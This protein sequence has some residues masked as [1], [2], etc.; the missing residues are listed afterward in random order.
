MGFLIPVSISFYTKGYMGSK[1]SEILQVW[2]LLES[3]LT[4]GWHWDLYFTFKIIFPL[5]FEGFTSSVGIWHPSL[6]QSFRCSSFLSLWRILGFMTMCFDLGPSYSSS[7]CR[8]LSGP[9]QSGSP[10]SP[11]WG[12][13]LCYFFANFLSLLFAS[14][15]PLL[16]FLLY[17]PW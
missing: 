8:V 12:I 6:S 7:L 15:C 10:C 11:F 17:F 1:F 13:F 5:N 16:C 4:F 14:S 9:F 3:L 2:K